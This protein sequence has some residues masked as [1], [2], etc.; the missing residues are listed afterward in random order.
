MESLIRE[1]LELC[2]AWESFEQPLP[3]IMGGKDCAEDL[4]ALLDKYKQ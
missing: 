4:Q 3:P 2:E 1:L